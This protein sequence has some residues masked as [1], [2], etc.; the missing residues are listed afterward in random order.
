MSTSRLQPSTMKRFFPGRVRVGRTQAEPSP[1][2]Q[3]LL[4]RGWDATSPA[5]NHNPP[6]GS[7]GCNCESVPLASHQGGCSVEKALKK[8]N[9]E[10]S[11]KSR[12]RSFASWFGAEKKV[13]ASPKRGGKEI[14]E[15]DVDGRYYSKKAVGVEQGQCPQ[16]FLDVEQGG[17]GDWETASSSMAPKETIVRRK[18][19][20]PGR[21]VMK[22]FQSCPVEPISKIPTVLP[23]VYPPSKNGSPDENREPLSFAGGLVMQPRKAA[24]GG[25][26]RREVFGVL[27][28][29]PRGGAAPLQRC[30]STVNLSSFAQGG[31][32][33]EPVAGG[34]LGRIKRP[35]TLKRVASPVA[36]QSPGGKYLKRLNDGVDTPV[37]ILSAHSHGLPKM[38]RKSGEGVRRQ[39]SG[40]AEGLLPGLSQLN[41]GLRSPAEG[42]FDPPKDSPP[43]WKRRRVSCPRSIA[44][45]MPPPP[46]YAS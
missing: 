4:P 19:V 7:S 32:K 10:T 25:G 34:E 42:V 43:I 39:S 24:P 11:K 31:Q 18:L 2:F 20:F 1:P 41:I 33:S 29:K 13:V 15:C 28:E 23:F 45:P 38:R 21:P 8:R 22:A 35:G 12:P 27:E 9:S 44:V 37:L 36:I 14:A 5:A 17:G 30:K 6:P 16:K 3:A 26:A 40:S 46:I